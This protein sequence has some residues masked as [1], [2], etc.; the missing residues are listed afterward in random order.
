MDKQGEE[1]EDE[2]EE[3][4]E[5]EEAA[6]V[7]SAQEI[8]SWLWNMKSSILLSISLPFLPQ[9]ACTTGY[10]LLFSKYTDYWLSDWYRS[11]E[12]GDY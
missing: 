12:A 9:G 2:E 8:I 7:D 10:E 5:E 1:E 11:L 3:E 4:E 6:A